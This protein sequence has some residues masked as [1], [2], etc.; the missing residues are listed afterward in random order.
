MLAAKKS[1]V[2][3]ISHEIRT[4]LNAAFLGLKLLIDDVA[5]SP[6]PD[7]HDRLEILKDIFGACDEGINVLNELLTY[8]KLES[9]LLTL[10]VDNQIVKNCHVLSLES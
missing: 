6:H 5:N 3:Y 7:D 4:P 8:D 2:R 9:G 10:N 1:Y